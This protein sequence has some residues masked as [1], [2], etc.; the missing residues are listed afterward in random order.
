MDTSWFFTA[1][2]QRE[3]QNLQ[4]LIEK[5]FSAKKVYFLFKKFLKIFVLLSFEGRTQGI[6]RFPG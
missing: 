2:P 6:W 5:Y 3:F 4:I 1:E